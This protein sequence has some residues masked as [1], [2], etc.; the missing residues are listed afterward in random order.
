MRECTVKQRGKFFIVIDP[1][2]HKSFTLNNR[3]EAESL[4]ETLNEAGALREDFNK[5][6]DW[7]DERKT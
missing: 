2:S 7:I 6:S 5:I 3:F 4:C 1:F